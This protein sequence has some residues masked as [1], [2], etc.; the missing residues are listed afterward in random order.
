MGDGREE[1]G[2]W[3]MKAEMGGKERKGKRGTRKRGRKGDQEK[4]EKG[5]QEKGDEGA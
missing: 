5:D 2:E 1:S 3:V 4:G